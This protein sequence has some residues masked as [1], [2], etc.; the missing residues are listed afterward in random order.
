LL[1]RRKALEK[2]ALG[3]ARRVHFQDR[4]GFDVH[5]GWSA[6]ATAG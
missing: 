1:I 5:F 4:T 2:S 3:F 6:A